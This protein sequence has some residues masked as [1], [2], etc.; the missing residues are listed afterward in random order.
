MEYDDKKNYTLCKIFKR[1][2]TFRPACLGRNVCIRFIISL[3]SKFNLYY[4]FNSWSQGQYISFRGILCSLNIMNVPIVY[5]QLLSGVNTSHSYL[6]Q[7]SPVRCIN[8]CTVFNTTVF[9]FYFLFL[10]IYDVLITCTFLSLR[11]PT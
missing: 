2:P 10:V 8:K 11:S 1:I 6:H 5:A 9:T 4:H 7:L 3:Q